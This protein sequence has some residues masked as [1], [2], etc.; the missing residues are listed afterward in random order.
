MKLFGNAL[1]RQGGL[2]AV[3]AVTEYVGQ[4]VQM[5]GYDSIAFLVALGAVTPATEVCEVQVDQGAGLAT[6]ATWSHTVA[7]DQGILVEIESVQALT[8]RFQM[9]RATSVAV[10][11]GVVALLYN[12]R[13]GPQLELGTS[14]HYMVSSFGVVH[15]AVTVAL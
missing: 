10:V 3:T 5:A 14:A 13:Y 4:T 7:A 12:R 1:V 9:I 8:A 11:D 6:F 15:P 2:S